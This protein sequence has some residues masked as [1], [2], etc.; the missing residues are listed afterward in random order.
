MLLMWA[1]LVGLTKI[2]SS[3]LEFGEIKIW[4]CKLKKKCVF[5]D[6]CIYYFFHFGVVCLFVFVGIRIKM[7]FK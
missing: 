3:E 2:Y 6:L 1:F 5:I 7:C 4:F